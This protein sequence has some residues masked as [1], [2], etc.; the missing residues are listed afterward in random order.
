MPLL[1]DRNNIYQLGYQG[2]AGWYE[3]NRPNDRNDYFDNTFSGDA[4][5]EFIGPLDSGGL[6]ELG[7][8]ARRPRYW[9]FGGSGRPG[10][11]RAD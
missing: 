8:A 3:V 5:M 6:C 4:H 11:S 10:H 7:R 2:E 1:Q 9:S